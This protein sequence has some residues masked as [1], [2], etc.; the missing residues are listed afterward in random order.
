MTKDKNP[1]V[2]NCWA[3]ARKIQNQAHCQN[4]PYKIRGQEPLAQLEIDH[5]HN[6]VAGSSHDQ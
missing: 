1:N 5:Y 3:K 6:Q 4:D 2:P